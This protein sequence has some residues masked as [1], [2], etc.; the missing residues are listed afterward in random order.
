MNMSKQ[1]QRAMAAA[2]VAVIL[3]LLRSLTAR[4]VSRYKAKSADGHKIE[5]VHY[6]PGFFAH[7]NQ[8]L[9]RVYITMY[10]QAPDGEFISHPS[11]YEFR[12]QNPVARRFAPNSDGVMAFD[13]NATA[14]DLLDLNAYLHTW[15]PVRL[16]YR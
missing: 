11:E 9:Y 3:P 4:G 2:A 6:K 14:Q 8:V 13:R 5:V 16:D 10:T 7:R 12:R 1:D 15:E